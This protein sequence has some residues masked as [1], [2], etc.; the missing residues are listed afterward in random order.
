MINMAKKERSGSRIEVTFNLL[1]KKEGKRAVKNYR[2]GHLNP[3][4]SSSRLIKSI[5]NSSCSSINH[6]H[7]K[8]STATAIECSSSSQP[9]QS[10]VSP[11]AP[12]QNYRRTQ[13]NSIF[14]L[15]SCLST[16]SL[17]STSNSSST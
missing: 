2:H 10:K 7:E 1:Q 9:S 5:D 6:C 8:Q 12:K 15:C 4:L 14:E 3:L 17:S 16:S 13:S 11:Q